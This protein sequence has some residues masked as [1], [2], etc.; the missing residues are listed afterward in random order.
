MTREEI[1]DNVTE[2][3]SS[4]DEQNAAETEV[5]EFIGDVEDRVNE[6]KS[7]I[8]IQGV[9]DIGKISEAFNKVE[10]LA[11]DLF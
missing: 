6:I 7:L 11:R 1:I 5:K 2:C 8:D 10:E 4:V 3:I 9:E